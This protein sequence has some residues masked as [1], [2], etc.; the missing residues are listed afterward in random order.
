MNVGGMLGFCAVDYATTGHN[1][2]G[3]FAFW[4]VPG[5]LSLVSWGCTKYMEKRGG[6]QQKSDSTGIASAIGE[7]CVKR[8][9]T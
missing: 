4:F 8:T 2:L 5:I 9:V 7:I 3:D 6:L 1:L